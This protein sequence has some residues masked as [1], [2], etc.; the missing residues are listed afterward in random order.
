MADLGFDSLMVVDLLTD[1]AKAFPALAARR[2]DLV[3]GDLTVKALTMRV[4]ALLRE[5]SESRTA[6]RVLPDTGQE[7]ESV[8]FPL[9]P[10]TH[11]WLD[12]HRIARVP[13]VPMA[14]V[15]DCCV[16][17]LQTRC[18]DSEPWALVDV[19]LEA[20]ARVTADR[21]DLTV[22]IHSNPEGESG[23]RFVAVLQG[24]TIVYRARARVIRGTLPTLSEPTDGEPGPL[25]ADAFYARHAFHGPRLRGVERRPEVGRGHIAGTIRVPRPGSHVAGAVDAFAIDAALQLAAYWTAVR[26]GRFAL[27][28]GCDEFRWL[29]P[30]PVTDELHVVA[31]LRA[32]GPEAITADIDLCSA[33]GSPVAQLRG[34]RARLQVNAP[35]PPSAAPTIEPERYRFEDFPEVR[36]LL[37]RLDGLREQGL[38]VPYFRVHEG[39]T[40]DRTSIAGRE[41][42]NFSSYNYLGLSG[43]P[44]LTRTAVRA[45]V[46]YGTSV[47]ASRV[48][49]GE[50][51]VH[52]ELESALARFLGCE[53]A[54]VF[55]SGHATNVSV[56]GHLLGQEDLI[57]HDALAHDSILGGAR[58]SGARR[59]PF[60]HNDMEA[61]EEVL[62]SMR[63]QAR[64][65][66]IAVE[67]VYS[68]DGDL[69]P[70]DR[71]IELKRR[72]KALLLVDEAHSLGVVGRTGR[73]IGEHY[74]VDRG[75][76]DLWMGTLS[77]SLAS[78]GG[79]ITG[80]RAVVNYLKYSA[81]G[82]VYSVGIS[83]ANAAAALAALKKLEV[84]PDLVT[85]LRA[86]PVVP[87]PVPG[88]RDRHRA[89]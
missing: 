52:R 22:R 9:G 6:D 2:N 72:Y 65:V 75:D 19:N 13:V 46:R 34:L 27:P 28:V 60:P 88:S 15:L 48:A 40:R 59:R 18:G 76:V 25:T 73:G 47:S 10:R 89:K 26:L 3:E 83:P 4:A 30:M 29:G 51:P 49:S 16:A 32:A 61:L 43:D 21:G 41:Y 7:D 78:C 24:G 66:L 69:A 44:Q 55:V 74:G 54:I 86:Q 64:R 17:A 39:I 71:L 23:E 77:K 31:T 11:A 62:S 56:L 84:R 14:V 37:H 12:D 68:M 85:C 38:S 45:A 20:G 8:I 33:D 80:S 82:F 5:Q 87:R 81:P 53:D 79:Y 57:L 63:S 50:R 1:L 36:A 58:L 35:A 70:L 42:I 67:G